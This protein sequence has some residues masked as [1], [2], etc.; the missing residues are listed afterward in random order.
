MRTPVHFVTGEG[1][2]E[3]ATEVQANRPGW[4]VC[5]SAG[6]P[7][8]TGRVVLQVTLARLLREQRP[9]RVLVVAVAQ[10]HDD[11]ALAMLRE[12]PLGVY[13]MEGRP[14]RLPRDSTLAPEALERD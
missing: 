12:P 14:I 7:C 3:W 6:C 4:A 9:S 5:L 11:T 13:L 2:R 10:T 1:A 8:C